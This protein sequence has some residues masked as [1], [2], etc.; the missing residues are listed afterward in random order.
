MGALGQLATGRLAKLRAS[1]ST[2]THAL[3]GHSAGSEARMRSS[4]GG[5]AFTPLPT[6]DEDDVGWF[7]SLFLAPRRSRRGRP[8]LAAAGP[9][10]PAA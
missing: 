1:A 9:Q 4:I 2:S 7:N 6:G 10:L 5:S 3:L 8:A